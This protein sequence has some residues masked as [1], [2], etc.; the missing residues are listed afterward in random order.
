MTFNDLW[1]YET[2]S[3]SVDRLKIIEELDFILKQYLRKSWF[4]NMKVTF[5]DLWDQGAFL[6]NCVHNV[7]T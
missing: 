2:F 5:Y 3:I 4:I 7:S 1:N 6:P